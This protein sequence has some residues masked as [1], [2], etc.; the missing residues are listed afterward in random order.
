[1]RIIV[2][3]GRDYADGKRIR[4]VLGEYDRRD[5]WRVVVVHGGC[6]G[7]DTLAALAAL[8][9]GFQ[10]EEWAADWRRRGRRA[11]PLRN[12]AMVDRGA[13]LVVAFPGGA[14]TADL[15]RRARAAGIEVREEWGG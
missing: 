1:M 8:D 12:Q 15:V 10:A 4:E 7:A 5:P 6:R 3:G 9:L 14:G 13:D 2:C 11:G